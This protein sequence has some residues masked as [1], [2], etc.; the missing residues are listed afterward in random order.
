MIRG[1]I[2][3]MGQWK[4]DE[5]PVLFTLISL[6]GELRPLRAVDHIHS[7]YK[8]LLMQWM[9]AMAGTVWQKYNQ[10]MLSNISSFLCF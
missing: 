6:M 10:S 1:K 5:K 8:A 4:V 7:L 9:H 2:G 3:E